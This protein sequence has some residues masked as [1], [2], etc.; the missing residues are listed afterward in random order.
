VLRVAFSIPGEPFPK[1]RPRVVKGHAFTPKKT[2]ARERAVGLA[3]K[4]AAPRGWK[5]LTGPVA[6]SMRFCR[7]TRQRVDLDNLAKS[8][9]DGLN[10]IAFAD[11]SQ[12]VELLAVKA[13]DPEA[14]GTWVEVRELEPVGVSR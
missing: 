14:P 12:I 8:I 6:L 4:V 2:L 3:F 7:S 9:L 11:D 13:V 1:E 5:P 10:G